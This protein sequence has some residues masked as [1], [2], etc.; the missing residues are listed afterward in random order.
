MKK[1]SVAFVLTAS[2]FAMS[3]MAAD[4]WTGTISD[5]KCGAKHADASEEGSMKCAQK[6]VKGG[7]TPVFI[8]DGKVITLDKDSQA[9]VMD[10]VGHKVV[11]TGKLDG[12]SLTI[13]TVKTAS[14]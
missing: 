3:A 7:A 14:D 2:L 6:C 10:H 11:V 5:S 8:T 9:K 12:D 1:L 4:S 13:D